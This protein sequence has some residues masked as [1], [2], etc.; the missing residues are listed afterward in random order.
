M[1]NFVV[2]RR[3]R[4]GGP[5]SIRINNLR[6]GEACQSEGIDLGAVSLHNLPSTPMWGEVRLESTLSN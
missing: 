1:W 4:D 6:G 2:N 5:L 3:R